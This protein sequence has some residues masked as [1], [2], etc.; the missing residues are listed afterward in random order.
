MKVTITVSKSDLQDLDVTVE[1]LK[2]SVAN[3]L[4]GGLVV[5]GDPS[6]PLY[7]NGVDIAVEVL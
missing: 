1:Q 2:E 7:L 4:N 6:T 3:Q 5:D